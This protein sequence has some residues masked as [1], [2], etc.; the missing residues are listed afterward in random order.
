MPPEASPLSIVLV[1]PDK[2]RAIQIIDSLKAA[3]NYDIRVIAENTGL[4]R[5]VASFNPD[6]VLV[7]LAN[8]RAILSKSCPSPRRRW[9]G[10]LPCSWTSPTTP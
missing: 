9:S 2:N 1:E 10:R 3:G 8:P 6:V 4:A 5:A 7:D